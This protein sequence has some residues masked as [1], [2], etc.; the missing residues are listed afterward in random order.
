ML[1]CLLA[2]LLLLFQLF[3]ALRPFGFVIE[4]SWNCHGKNVQFHTNIFYTFFKIE[5]KSKKKI[6]FTWF[7]PNH[8]CLLQD[9]K[10]SYNKISPCRKSHPTESNYKNESPKKNDSSLFWLKN[11]YWKICTDL[12][13]QR[14]DVDT[15][16]RYE[17]S[18]WRKNKKLIIHNIRSVYLNIH[19]N[20]YS[21]N[22]YATNRSKH[23]TQTQVHV[24]AMRR[25]NIVVSDVFH[26]IVIFMSIYC[27]I[28]KTK[29]HHIHCLKNKWEEEHASN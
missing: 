4:Y 23:Y 12:K 29:T 28:S 13:F 26:I 11:I 20:Y 18:K 15:E 10:T 27:W 14:I 22:L 16:N 21:C 17:D 1:A 3:V 2:Y 6:F 24:Y 8:S 25:N 9:S 5:Q 7:N 19:S